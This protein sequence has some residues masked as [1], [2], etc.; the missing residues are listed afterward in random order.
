MKDFSL[1]VYNIFLKVKGNILCDAEVLH[2]V[3]HNNP[4]L[5]A[6]PEKMIYPCLA[7]KNYGS[8]VKYIDLLMTKILNRDALNLDKGFKFNFQIVFLSQLKIRRFWILRFRL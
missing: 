8:K 5:A 7:G 6:Y 3:G 2:S 1:S 4:H